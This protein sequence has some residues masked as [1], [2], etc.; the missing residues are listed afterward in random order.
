MLPFVNDGYERACKA[1]RAEVQ[2][3]YARQFSEANDKERKVLLKKIEAEVR[4]RIERKAPPGAL[5]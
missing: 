5:Y 2:S 1:I 4:A 3:K